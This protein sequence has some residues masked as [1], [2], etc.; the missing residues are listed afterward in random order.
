MEQKNRF[1]TVRAIPENV[2]ET[3]T[4][5][6]IASDESIDRHGSICRADKWVLD[7]FNANPIIGWQHNV[8][9]GG[10]CSDPDPDQI[11]GKG[12]AYI[13]GNQ[14]LVDITFEDGENNP[15]AE[16][17]FNKVKNGILNAGSVGFLGHGERM[18][19]EEH[20]EN[21]DVIYFE[22]Q[23]LIEFSV[24]SIPS[25]KNALK[26]A[27]RSQTYDALKFIYKELGGKF[28]FSEIE[29]MKVKD[30]I[31]MMEGDDPTEKSVPKKREIKVTV[32]Q[33]LSEVKNQ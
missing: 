23:E 26:K 8:Y 31:S 19:V 30:V 1:G 4:V 15:L 5:T 12:R 24:V 22:S 18:G 28:R 33:T 13:E 14:L 3:R 2:D 21:P 25:N 29:E 9:G 16:K 27:L 32:K 10:M 20:G 17:V 7:H 11:I 6:F